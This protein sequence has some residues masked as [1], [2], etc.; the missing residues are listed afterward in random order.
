MQL[1]NLQSYELLAKHAVFAKECC[2]RCGRMLGPVRFTRRGEDGVWCSR[3]CRGVAEAQRPKTR[4]ATLCRRLQAT[5]GRLPGRVVSSAAAKLPRTKS[6]RAASSPEKELAGIS[7]HPE[8]FG[9]G[10]G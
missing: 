3:R 4:R 1:G 8:A 6:I 5:Q 7:G 9:V 2:D 10:R